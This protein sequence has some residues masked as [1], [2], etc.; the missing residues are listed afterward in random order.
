MGITQSEAVHHEHNDKPK[1]VKKDLEPRWSLWCL[2]L[3]SKLN[4]RLIA[5]FFS[6]VLN[7]IIPFMLLLS[8]FSRWKQWM[9]MNSRTSTSQPVKWLVCVQTIYEYI[10]LHQVLLL[11][12]NISSFI[13]FKSITLLWIKISS[14]SAS[15]SFRLNDINCWAKTLRALNSILTYFRFFFYFQAFNPNQNK[16]TILK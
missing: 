14:H 9:Y 7:I 11:Q 2:L 5:F 12:D 13:N 15:D 6:Y 4:I 3:L 8:L 16:L 1:T 10:L